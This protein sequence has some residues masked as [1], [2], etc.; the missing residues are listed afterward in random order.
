[1]RAPLCLVALVAVCG[2]SSVRAAR[3]DYTIDVP[4]GSEA[5]FELPFPV[6]YPGTV[7]ID[8]NWTG[9]RL[10]FFGVEGP[11]RA[12]LARRSGPSPQRVEL[13]ADPTTIARGTGW[14]LTI[15][16]LPARGAASG[17][18]RVT[19]PDAPE[20]IARREAELHPP[21]PPPPPPP[22]WSLPKAAPPGALPDTAHVYEAVEAYRAAVLPQIAGPDDS[23]G[24][25]LEFLK[26][27]VATRDRLGERGA[28]PDVATLRY[29]AK[30]TEAAR[31]VDSLR[32]GT[33][34]VIGGPAPT[35][36]DELRDW[37][38]SRGE[39]VRPI[40]RSLDS[41]TELLRGGHAPAM[42]DE[43][44]LPRLTACL[45][46]CER[47]FDERVRI[48]NAEDAPNGAL[49]A[50]QWN[51]ILA[52]GGVFAAFQPFLKEPAPPDR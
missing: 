21:P 29:F 43:A 12:A 8:A 40:V 51:R 26:F 34:P 33:D 36:R 7:T 2:L 1:M 6:A 32:T 25:Q 38:M 45:T 4:D 37:L 9:P 30:L 23:C 18:L 17:S 16:A 41:L 15:K 48:G 44:W 14:K 13:T 35:D 27:A 20:I 3:W 10:L 42:Q 52:A 47:Y 5:T 50:A 49:A 39:I 46:A 11:D 31:G 24:W 19:C 22:A 28:P